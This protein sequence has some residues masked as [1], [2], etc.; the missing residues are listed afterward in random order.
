M[1]NV[2]ET[3]AKLDAKT[4][5]ILARDAK[6]LDLSSSW[7]TIPPVEFNDRSQPIKFEDISCSLAD[8]LPPE[9]LDVL[10]QEVDAKSEGSLAAT[11]V[12]YSFEQTQELLNKSEDLVCILKVLEAK[13]PK[14]EL[15]P[16]IKEKLSHFSDFSD[17]ESDGVVADAYRKK[18]NKKILD[19]VPAELRASHKDKREE[20]W[21]DP[22]RTP[23][24][25][26]VEVRD[27][28]YGFV[29]SSLQKQAETA[30][31]QLGALHGICKRSDEAQKVGEKEKPLLLFREV[32]AVERRKAAVKLSLP[33]LCAERG[34]VFSKHG[35]SPG[36][37]DFVSDQ[38]T[39]EEE[40]KKIEKKSGDF[41]FKKY[42]LVVAL[43]KKLEKKGLSPSQKLAACD[44]MLKSGYEDKDHN[45]TYSNR[46]LLYDHRDDRYFQHF[47]R[48]LG[49]CF[50]FGHC[51]FFS[52]SA[53]VVREFD[54]KPEDA[55]APK[56]LRARWFD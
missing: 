31:G 9:V 28:V 19:C 51:N 1:P 14:L 55:A 44:D 23:W 49:R 5:R 18:R 37:L 13:F 40:I 52:K 2:I 29:G 8:L 30:A 10:T 53:A 17:P 46:R 47:L 11:L 12:H 21:T 39:N 25:V 43:E 34:K 22:T 38:K 36:G 48:F 15:E 4:L 3:L 42:D 20:W 32:I 16:Q 26:L 7:K 33:Y 41:I 35:G 45:L 54:T 50:T 24:E 27:Y 6:T 56:P